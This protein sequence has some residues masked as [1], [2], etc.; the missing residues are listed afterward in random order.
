MKMKLNLNGKDGG[1]SRRVKPWQVIVGVIAL[2]MV[3]AVGNTFAGSITV[4][5][6]QNVEFGQ[7]VA[8]AAA[9]DSNVI[10]TPEAKY[11]TG[12]ANYYLETITVSSLELR[13][14][15]TALNNLTCL[16]KTFKIQVLD[17]SNVIQEWISAGVST[18]TAT[19]SSTSGTNTASGVTS[20][21]VA[22][23]SGSGTSSGSLALKVSTPYLLASSVT[24]ILIQTQ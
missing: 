22:T 10:I 21:L 14:S 5:S 7:G 18:G 19:P 2:V 8:S 9:C 12:S 6:A 3:P 11:V 23:V 15:T 17:G 13:D 20:G 24:K 16:G 1:K 4:N